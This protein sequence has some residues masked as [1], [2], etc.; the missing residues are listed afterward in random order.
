MLRIT[1]DM[2]DVDFER[3]RRINNV[4]N[5]TSNRDQTGSEVTR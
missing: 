3:Q 4:R 2:N 1:K 5:P